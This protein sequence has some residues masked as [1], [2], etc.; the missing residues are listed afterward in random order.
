MLTIDE[1]LFEVTNQELKTL[2]A[3][4]FKNDAIIYVRNIKNNEFI[5]IINLIKGEY[6]TFCLKSYVE[7]SISHK[8]L[9][10]TPGNHPGMTPY[11]I[12]AFIER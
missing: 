1:N 2:H 3:S 9:S 7:N 4:D 12:R 5:Y 8:K 10:C 11:Y 6:K